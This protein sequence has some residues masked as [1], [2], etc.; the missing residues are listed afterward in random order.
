VWTGGAEYREPAI[1]RVIDLGNLA[2]EL[3]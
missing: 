2:N 3:L 1:E